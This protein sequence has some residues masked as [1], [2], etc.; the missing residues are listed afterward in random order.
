MPNIKKITVPAVKKGKRGR[1]K[2]STEKVATHQF[3][4]E[5]GCKLETSIRNVSASCKHGYVM[6]YTKTVMK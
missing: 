2:G 4:A 5:D 3:V 6:E 1:P